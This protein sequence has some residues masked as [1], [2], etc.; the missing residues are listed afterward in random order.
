[1]GGITLIDPRKVTPLL[2]NMTVDCKLAKGPSGNV[3]AV[4][5]RIDGKKLA[6]KHISI[7]TSDAETRAL[8]YAGAVKNEAAA[9]RYYTSQVKELKNELLLLN[10]VKNAANL[11]KFRGYQVD[12]KYTGVGYDVYLLS[13]FYP[14]LP[15]S[16]Q[17]SPLTKLQARLTA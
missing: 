3:Y 5:R 13:D 11:L 16:I 17:K 10:N 6:L 12:Q 14:N 9:Q 1:M 15:D 4:S 8:I 7:P 2:S